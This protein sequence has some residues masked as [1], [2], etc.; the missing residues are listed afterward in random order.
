M[1]HTRNPRLL[2]PPHA[3]TR[4]RLGSTARTLQGMRSKTPTTPQPA[5]PAPVPAVIVTQDTAELARLRAAL[6][7]AES[8]RDAVQA[9][10]VA[11]AQREARLDAITRPAPQVVIT[12]GW[13]HTRNEL[14]PQAA[15]LIKLPFMQRLRLWLKDRL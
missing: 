4:A 1:Q 13:I 6:A 12:R 9:A 2:L 15:V 3:L 14:D 10:V 5:P 7:Q 8:E 11:R